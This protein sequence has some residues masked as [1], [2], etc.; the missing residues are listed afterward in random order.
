ML[1]END[2]S[3]CLAHWIAHKNLLHDMEIYHLKIYFL[4]TDEYLSYKNELI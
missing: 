4:F 1:T 3:D 2:G